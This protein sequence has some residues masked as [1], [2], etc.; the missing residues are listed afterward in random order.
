MSERRSGKQRA[1]F[2]VPL[3][4]G[5]GFDKQI[6]AAVEAQLKQHAA[7]VERLARVERAKGRRRVAVKLRP[8][9]VHSLSVPQRRAR[10]ERNRALAL[11]RSQRRRPRHGRQYVTVPNW[12]KR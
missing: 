1:G 10:R 7:E 4:R 2:H 12:L 3:M 8:W 5:M 9:D 11:R 6:D